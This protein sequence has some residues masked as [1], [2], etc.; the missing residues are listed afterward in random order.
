MELQN[1]Q[2]SLIEKESIYNF[3]IKNI[4]KN[5]SA[6]EKEAIKKKNLE[7]RN[8]ELV[9][10]ELKHRINTIGESA[11]ENRALNNNLDTINTSHISTIDISF[12]TIKFEN[13]KYYIKQSEYDDLRKVVSIMKNHK[14]LKIVVKGI[15]HNNNLC[16]GKILAYDRSSNVISHLTSI[17]KIPRERLILN[18]ESKEFNTNIKHVEFIVAT[19]HNNMKK[20]ACAL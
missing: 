9:I 5:Y 12:P 19:N 4:E 10:K 3:T 8:K 6:K 15:S 18:W 2:K 7:I 11:N 13:S 14:D 16:T 1:Y 17:Y 20:P